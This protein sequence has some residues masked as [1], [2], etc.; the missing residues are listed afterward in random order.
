MKIPNRP[1]RLNRTLL[2]TAGLILLAAGAFELGTRSGVIRLVPRHQELLFLPAHPP[3]WAAYV[4][5]AAAIVAG[6]AALRWLAAQAGRRR[7]RTALWRLTAD[8]ERGVTT[9]QAATAAAPLAADVET[10]DGVRA[11]GAWLAGPRHSPVL[12]LD[13]R[14]DH[15]ADLTALRRDISD[16]AMPRLRTA[17]ELD[18]LPAAI[19]II[20]TS[21]STRAR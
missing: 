8:P 6:L 2:F 17:L 21:A 3:R 19:L 10:Y 20:P 15:D 16:H 11:A 5:L 12:Y 9:M 4:A 7:P 1:A 13:V 18:D 14:T